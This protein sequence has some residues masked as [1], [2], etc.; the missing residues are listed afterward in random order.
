MPQIPSQMP[1]DDDDATAHRR[2]ATMMMRQRIFE[3]IQGAFAH[4]RAH[5][6][7][8][9]DAIKGDIEKLAAIATQL[10]VKLMNAVEEFNV[11]MAAVEAGV[12]AVKTDMVPLSD[13][14]RVISDLLKAKAA[15]NNDAVLAQAA[16]RLDVV[17]TG[18]GDVDAKLKDAHQ[19]LSDAAAA[20]SASGGDAQPVG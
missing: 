19:G 4:E 12:A 2:S 15:E 16:T 8:R 7:T 5:F 1:H 10:G 11:K 20:V 3:T 17:V 13:E 9:L 6:N 18:L 14:V